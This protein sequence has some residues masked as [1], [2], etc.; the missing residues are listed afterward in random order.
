VFADFDAYDG[1]GPVALVPLAADSPM[2]GEWVVVCDARGKAAALCAWEVPGQV[3]VPERDRLFE[4]VWTVDPVAVRDAAR[5]CTRVVDEAGVTGALELELA[6][7]EPV[8]EAKADLAYV[9]AVFNRVVA[10]VD[11][12]QR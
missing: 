7:I 11:H 6:L 3:G 8:P 12:F 1:T 2:H 4:A 5:V 10:Y 9:T